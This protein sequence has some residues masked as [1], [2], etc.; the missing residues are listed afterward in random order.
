MSELALIGDIGGTN[1]RFAL[2]DLAASKPGVMHAQSFSHAGFHGLGD[3]ARHYLDEVDAKPK[4]AALA[5]AAPIEGDKVILTNR[6]W[7]FRRHELQQVLGLDALRLINDFAAIAWSVPHLAESE[8]LT[9]HGEAATPPQT[10]VTLIGAGTGLGV[11]H[12]TGTAADG[13]Q[14]YPGEGG[15]ATYAPTDDEERVID[16]WIRKRHGRTSNER[17]LSGRGLANID[18]ALRG[19]IPVAAPADQP[20][21]RSPEAITESALSGKDDDARRALARFCRVYGAVAGDAALMHGA[22]TVLVAGGVVLHVLDFFRT[23]AFMEAFT[24]KG[25]TTGYMQRMAVEVITHPNPGLLGAAVAARTAAAAK[26]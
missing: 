9:L 13:W 10:P 20:G 16:A 11:A 18:A 26:S 19:V 5:V 1:A 3:A 25:R 4:C 21:L 12:L 6:G 7:S 24:A 23:S 2:T 17:M 22:N 15:H 8:R 14:V